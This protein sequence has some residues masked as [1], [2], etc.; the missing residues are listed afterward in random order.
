[1][2]KVNPIIG[3]KAIDLTYVGGD[4]KRREYEFEPGDVVVQG[5]PDGRVELKSK[6]EKR[7]P[8]FFVLGD[9]AIALAYVGGD[10]KRKGWMREPWEHVFEPGD[11]VIQRLPDGGIALKSK[12]GPL[13]V[14]KK[15]NA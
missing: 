4:G 12:S 11:V 5:L 6:S 2:K 8:D 10:G 7:L 14:L 15:W 9:T 13:W 3:D 1:M